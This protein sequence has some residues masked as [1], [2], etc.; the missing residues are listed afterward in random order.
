MSRYE[1]DRIDERFKWVG[2]D[3]DG[4]ILAF[5]GR[6]VKV[7]GY[8]VGSNGDNPSRLDPYVVSENY[9]E[10]S[11]EHR[12]NLPNR[13]RLDPKRWEDSGIRDTTTNRYLTLGDVLDLL[14]ERSEA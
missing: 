5:S 4:V 6:P 3:S 14:N 12:P 1:W 7:G 13:Y 8:W 11:L 2:V 9:W 10:E